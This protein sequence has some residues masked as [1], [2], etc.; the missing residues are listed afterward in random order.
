LTIDKGTV[1]MRRYACNPSY[2]GGIEQEDCSSKPTWANSSARPY[3][4]KTLQ[5][6]KNRAGGVAQGEGPEFKPQYRKKK[7]RNEI[8]GMLL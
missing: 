7:K 8:G 2:S 4:K 5:K 3:L 6:K 1:E